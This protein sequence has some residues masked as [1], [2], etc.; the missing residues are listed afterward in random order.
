MNLNITEAEEEVIGGE[1]DLS[2]LQPGLGTDLVPGG[3]VEQKLSVWEDDSLWDLGKATDEDGGGEGGGRVYFPVPQLPSLEAP[4]LDDL[5]LLSW[6][7]QQGAESKDVD[8]NGLSEQE[9][10]FVEED[11]SLLLEA[12]FQNANRNMASEEDSIEQVTKLMTDENMN[13]NKMI[14]DKNDPMDRNMM[15]P[16]IIDNNVIDYDEIR[17]NNEVNISDKV[18]M[19]VAIVD[20]DLITERENRESTK[21]EEADKDL[22]MSKKSAVA[23]QRREEESKKKEEGLAGK[24]ESKAEPRS[25][26]NARPLAASKKV[27]ETLDGLVQGVEGRTDEGKVF[28]KYLGVPYAAPPLGSLRCNFNNRRNSWYS[29][30]SIHHPKVSTASA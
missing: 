29:V 27:V 17:T 2:E 1:A 11:L 25:I 6:V 3:D 4:M 14:S 28:H 15:V 24:G 26:G 8:S 10:L 13:I 19:K 21:K 18:T 20:K 22:E 7:E 9:V 16:K 5:P 23:G 30:H 12:G